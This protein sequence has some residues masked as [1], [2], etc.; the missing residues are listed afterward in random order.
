MKISSP[1]GN[2]HFIGWVILTLLNTSMV[3]VDDQ[4]NRMFLMMF[5]V[6]LQFVTLF[7]FMMDYNKLGTRQWKK[8]EERLVEEL[9]AEPDY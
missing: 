8:R 2:M 4:K 7:L 3:L 1:L 6:I 9:M 5:V